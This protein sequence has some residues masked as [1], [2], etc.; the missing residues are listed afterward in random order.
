MIWFHMMPCV[1]FFVQPWR[2]KV[3]LHN[4]QCLRIRSN[5]LRA[6]ALHHGGGTFFSE[7]KTR[8][9]MPQFKDVVW[10]LR[11]VAISSVMSNMVNL[12]CLVCV[13]FNRFCQDRKPIGIVDPSE[14]QR[15]FVHSTPHSI[16]RGVVWNRC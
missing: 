13:C 5:K 9:N 4:E 16:T 7:S 2:G 3:P 15:L 10:L 6:F 8:N 1:F 11:R 12:I 14:N